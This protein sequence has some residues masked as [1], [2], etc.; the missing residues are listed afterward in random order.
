MTTPWREAS[1]IPTTGIKGGQEQEMRATSATLAVLSAVPEFASAILKPFG[2]IYGNVETF[3]EVP[4]E[5]ANGKTIRPDGLIRVSRG[6]KS[7]TCLVEVKTGKNDLKIDQLESYLDIARANKFDALVTIS[8][9]FSPAVGIHPVKV[10]GN[11]LRSVKMFHLSW[12]ALITQAVIQHEHRGVADP[13]QAWILGELI[14]Y[15]EHPNSGALEFDDMGPHWVAVRNSAR[16][17]SLRKSD[18]GLDEIS[19]RWIEFMRFLALQLGKDLGAEVTQSLSQQERTDH[20]SRID[21]LKNQ[22][23]LDGTLSGRLRI[24]DAI[25][26]IRVAANLANRLVESSID[27]KAPSEGT[28]RSRI[29]WLLRQLKDAPDNARIDVRFERR[30]NTQSNTL[31]ALREDP[32]NGLL[33]DK[34][35]NPREFNIALPAEMGIKKGNLQGSFVESVQTNL[36]TFYREVVQVLKPWQQSAPKLPEPADSET[37]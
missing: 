15:L 18:A 5:S 24:P 33:E 19:N 36:Q 11:K 7:W 16:D 20:A 31:T 9:Q 28:P 3:V 13:D 23:E 6:K 26:D 22:L 8:N 17:R 10:N 21:T 35:V 32:N 34:K 25:S 30:S 4:F 27:V 2:A 12:I 29:T 1:L 37:S 14:K